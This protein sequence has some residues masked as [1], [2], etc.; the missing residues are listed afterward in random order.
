MILHTIFKREKWFARW[1]ANNP[2]PSAADI[3]RFHLRGGDGDPVND[4][5]MNRGN[6]LFTNSISCIRHS[7]ESAAF[8]YVDLRNGITTDSFLTFHKMIPVKA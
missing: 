4:L 1:I 7:L 2:N 3:I 5:N 6:K 8:R